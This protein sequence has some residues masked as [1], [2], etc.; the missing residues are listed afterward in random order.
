[1]AIQDFWD[2][3]AR[4]PKNTNISP[5]KFAEEYEA[6]F[7]T[8]TVEIEVEPTGEQNCLYGKGLGDLV[9]DL[10]EESIKKTNN[11]KMNIINN[12]F[13][14]KEN[15]ALELFD[16]GSVKQLND[17]GQSEFVD[18]LFETLKE[19]RKAFLDVIVKE[20]EKSINNK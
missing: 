6:I 3:V 7:S 12:V 17:R 16:M 14:T 18:F 20:Y 5:V 15:K 13:K 9:L 19:D 4:G 2:G 8:G 1:M 11:K 10:W